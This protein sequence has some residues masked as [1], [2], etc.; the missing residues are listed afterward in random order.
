MRSNVEHLRFWISERER[1]YKARQ[2]KQSPPWTDDPILASY[3][4]CNVRREH[5]KVT[6]WIAEFW[7]E[8]KATQRSF[9]AAL[10]L[11]RMLNNPECL[12]ELGYPG[13][14]DSPDLEERLK[15]RRARGAKILNAA[16][17]ITTCG[18]RMDKID[19][20]MRVCTNVYYHD[21]EARAGEKLSSFHA[22]LMGIRGLGQF[23]AAQVVADMKN[24]QG[25]SLTSAPD[26]WSWA[27]PGPGS[28]K[29]LAMVLGVSKISPSQFLQRAT[30]LKSQIPEANCLCMQ[31]FQ[32]CLCEISKYLRAYN[33]SGK[34]KQRYFARQ[35]GAEV[36][37]P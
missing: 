17:V 24:T 19:Y 4:F 33:G 21:F 26:W 27:A 15:A 5:D 29:G 20:I 35:D 37:V 6:Q 3:R 8:G 28:L 11:A 32:N 18:E 12:K 23:L 1:I 14:W 22:R 7:R 9:V 2:L 13:F 34:P 10:V 25:C 30:E 16:Y 31:D 36:R